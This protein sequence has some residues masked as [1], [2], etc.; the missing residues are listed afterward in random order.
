MLCLGTQKL[1]RSPW[2]SEKRGPNRLLFTQTAHSACTV[3][4]VP[5]VLGHKAI[6]PLLA[7]QQ[8]EMI[9]PYKVQVQREP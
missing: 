4:M 5:I 2:P 8:L 9:H 1:P 6:Y 7:K 3:P